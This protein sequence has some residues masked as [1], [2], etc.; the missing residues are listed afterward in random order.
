MSEPKFSDRNPFVV[1]ERFNGLQFGGEH[2]KTGISC[3]LCGVKL[4]IGDQARWI[5]ANSSGAGTGNFF[6]CKACDGEDAEV[7]ERAKASLAEA[8]R[9]AKQWSIYGPDWQNR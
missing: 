6:V 1:T 3:K 4:H 7:I 2:T 5:Y 9:L 8:T